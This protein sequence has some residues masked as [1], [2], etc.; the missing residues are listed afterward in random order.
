MDVESINS[1]AKEVEETS[2]YEKGFLNT[3]NVLPNWL[4]WV[5]VIPVSM[6]V[7]AL[8]YFIAYIGWYM[9]SG[10]MFTDGLIG[11]IYIGIIAVAVPV[12][13]S[14]ECVPKYKFVISTV[15]A[16]LYTVSGVVVLSM[17]IVTNPMNMSPDY[18]FYEMIPGLVTVITAIVMSVVLVK[19]KLTNKSYRD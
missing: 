14:H 2:E 19:H 13:I 15:L 1:E 10:Q 16:G 9:V 5:V 18:F 11:Q 8:L 6:V 17:A 12:F 7:Y 4:R 3:F